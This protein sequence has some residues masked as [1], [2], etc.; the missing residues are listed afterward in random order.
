MSSATPTR[1][2]TTNGIIK[3]RL[4]NTPYNTD[5]EIKTREVPVC[6]TINSD[7]NRDLDNDGSRPISARTENTVQ[8]THVQAQGCPHPE[9]ANPNTEK[10]RIIEE[11]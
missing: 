6:V 5:N 3:F 11:S 4:S 9:R 8:R 10:S 1:D 7:G 2:E